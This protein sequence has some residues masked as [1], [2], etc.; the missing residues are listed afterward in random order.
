MKKL[1]STLLFIAFT[2]IAVAQHEH[3]SHDCRTAKIQSYLKQ[4]ERSVLE[5][6]NPEMDKYDINFYHLD[7]QLN[8]NSVAIEGNVRLLASVLE[9]M[10]EF[11]IQL[12]EDLTVDS[13]YFNGAKLD[14]IHDNDEIHVTTPTLSPGENIDATIYYDGMPPTGG[15]FAGISSSYHSSYGYN[16]TWTLSEPYGA[17]EWFPVKQSLTDKI[18]SVY[19]YVTTDIDNIAASNGI[20]THVEDMGSMHRYEWKTNY[21]IDYYL[22]S[23]AVAE[24]Q[25]YSIYAHPEELENDSILIQNFIYDSPTIL[26]NLQDDID[27]TSELVEYLSSQYGLYPFHEE[28]YGNALTPLGGGMEHQTMTTIGSFSFG[29][30]AHELGHQWF[31]DNVTCATWSDIW[32]NEGFATYTEYLARYALNSPENGTSFIVSAQNN[33]MSSSGGSVYVPEDELDDI[34]RIFSSRLSYDKG[35]SLVHMIRFEMQNDED[36]FETLQTYQDIYKDST[37]TG[38]DFMAVCEQVSGKEFDTFFDQWY[39]GEGY[40][41]YDITYYNYPDLLEV[42]FEQESSTS[43]TPFF[44]MLME[45]KFSFEDNFDTIVQVYHTQ[46]TQ[47]EYYDDLALAHGELVAIDIDPNEWTLDKTGQIA[48]N[49]ENVTMESFGNVFP[50]PAKDYITVIKPSIATD[51]VKIKDVNGKLIIT[52]KYAAD[53]FTINIENFTSGIYFLEFGTHST[54]EPVKFIVQ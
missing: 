25:D 48:V 43:A 9:E 39:F 37:A 47:T 50:N 40:P 16:A 42:T 15:F 38:L 18:D 1:T 3:D 33:A 5:T 26:D 11:V 36:F 27:R 13:I 4:S 54:S 20:L 29:L 2:L 53:K 49:T 12:V 10:D 14:F 17:K 35:A 52:K 28:K 21:P 41:T 45:Y 8:E 34:W 32:V 19:V 46:A 24:Y 6:F 51:L 30:N 23:V 22:I 7:I 31:G 44:E